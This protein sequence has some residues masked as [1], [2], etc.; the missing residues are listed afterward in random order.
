MRH[1]PMDK[2]KFVGKKGTIDVVGAR[3]S[4]NITVEVKVVDVKNVYGRNLYQVT[5]IA[6][7]GKVWK[8]KVTFTK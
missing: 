8:E 4:G 5:P 6:G 7:A 2:E 1:N 3:D